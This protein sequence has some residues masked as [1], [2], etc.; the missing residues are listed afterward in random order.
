VDGEVVLV[1]LGTGGVDDR[2]QRRGAVPRVW[3]MRSRA[4]WN[5]D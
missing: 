2:D 5:G 3:S 4:S 1:V